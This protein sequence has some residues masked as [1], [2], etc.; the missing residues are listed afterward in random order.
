MRLFSCTVANM[1][2]GRTVT[3]LARAPSPLTP[4]PSPR[5]SSSRLFLSLPHFCEPFRRMHGLALTRSAHTHTHRA[6]F[7]A[8]IHCTGIHPHVPVTRA[9]MAVWHHAFCIL[10][11]IQ[12]LWPRTQARTSGR[13]PHR[14]VISGE[15]MGEGV[16]LHKCGNFF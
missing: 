2:R 12:S 10:D 16:G 1:E 11:S 15:R 3:P 4:P 14:A 8:F 13:A 5:R 6:H 7:T 9:G